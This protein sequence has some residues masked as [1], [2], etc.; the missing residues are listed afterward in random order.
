M[1]GALSS[2]PAVASILALAQMSAALWIADP[3][4][5]RHLRLAQFDQLQRWFP[6]P[7][8]PSPVR[9]VDIDELSLKPLA[10]GHWPWPR[11]RMAQLVQTLRE[12][13]AAAVAFDVLLAE[14]DR[15]S[16]TALAAQW[17]N[18]ALRRELQGLPDNDILLARTF[19]NVPVEFGISLA[20]SAS[21]AQAGLTSALEHP[22]YRVM[23]T[24]TE[25]AARA[26]TAGLDAYFYA[27]LPLP[28][29]Q[30]ATSAVG[31]L[32]YAPDADGV[33]RRLPLLFRL[34]DQVVPSLTAKVFRLT[35]NT[36]NYQIQRAEAGIDTV[37]IDQVSVPTDPQGA[38]WLAYTPSQP[39]WFLSA[40]KVLS[41]E[42]DH[43][44]LKGHVVLIG[45]S[46]AGLLDLRLNSMGKL[47]PGVTAHALALEQMLIQI[48]FQ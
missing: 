6:R 23:E 3:I 31:A 44:L 43:Q 32:N 11:T 2:L 12:D 9:I 27:V 47:M 25:A 20:R 14:P 17:Q 41:G 29:L 33:V 13:V 46:A 18:A 22:S 10:F 1:P 39:M 28:G 40:Q 21:A 8:T 48:C 45:S 7:Y 24:G 34:G 38:L 26:G 35:L 42:V 4:A 5:L 30:A 19:A 15:T 36:R 37:R 16:P